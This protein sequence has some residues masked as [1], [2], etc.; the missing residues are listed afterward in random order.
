M[1]NIVTQ[2]GNKKSKPQEVVI[3]HPLGQAAL[4]KGGGVLKTTAR[5]QGGGS[6]GKSVC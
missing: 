4:M 2:S 3:S 6:V 1:F 5:K